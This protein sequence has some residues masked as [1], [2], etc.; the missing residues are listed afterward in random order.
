MGRISCASKTRGMGAFGYQR[1][2]A[3]CGTAHCVR[4]SCIQRTLIEWCR[5]NVHT[6]SLP[7]K[8]DHT[9]KTMLLERALECLPVF[10]KKTKLLFSSE[11]L[12]ASVTEGTNVCL[13]VY[14][15]CYYY[16]W[17]WFFLLLFLIQI[18]GV[19]C[20]AGIQIHLFS[21][22]ILSHSMQI[23]HAWQDLSQLA[24]G[25]SFWIVTFRHGCFGTLKAWIHSSS[26]CN[27]IHTEER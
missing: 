3:E 6:L 16:W 20:C 13:F 2:W 17:H 15:C 9:I 19:K 25:C 22:W 24:M 27:S 18:W 21:N 4:V 10:Q 8:L 26:S 7:A 11:Y 5:V 1:R 12:F 23:S 14:V